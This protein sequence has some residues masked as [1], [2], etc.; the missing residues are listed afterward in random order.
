MPKWLCPYQKGSLLRL[1]IVPGARVSRVVGAHDDR[2][3]IKISSLPRDGEANSEIINF[4]S[5]L[6]GISK[7]GVEILRGEFGRSKD[8]YVDLPNEKI[9]ILLK[10]LS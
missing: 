9:L 7:S 1:Y 6:L 10:P 8:V 4:L 2:L 3:K 5:E